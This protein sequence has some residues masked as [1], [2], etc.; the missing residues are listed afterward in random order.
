MLPKSGI[1][2]KQEAG[3]GVYDDTLYETASRVLR[4]A[5]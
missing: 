5:L 4:G 3:V 2:S 1:Q